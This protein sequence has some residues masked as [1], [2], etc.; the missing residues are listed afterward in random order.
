MGNTDEPVK[1][2]FAKLFFL[3]LLGEIGVGGGNHPH[4]HPEHVGAA[5]PLHLAL[6]QKAQQLGLNAQ[7]QLADFVQK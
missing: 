7:R 1:Q 2:V 6:I 4:V 3:R 5:Q